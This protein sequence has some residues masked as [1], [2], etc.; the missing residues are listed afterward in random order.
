MFPQ[1]FRVFQKNSVC[2]CSRCEPFVIL[3]PVRRATIPK[4]QLLCW[5]S[6]MSCFLLKVG[7]AIGMCLWL[8]FVR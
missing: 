3:V 7:L 1:L 8:L 2:S 4:I 6:H 5:S